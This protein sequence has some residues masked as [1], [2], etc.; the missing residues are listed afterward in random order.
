MVA[1]DQGKVVGYVLA[2]LADD[3][4]DPTPH[5]HI[6]SLAVLRSHRKLGIATKLMQAAQTEM[7][8]VYDACYVTLHVRKSNTA[9]YH[10]YSQTLGY[11]TKSLEK[12]YYA[13][14]E[15]AYEMLMKIREETAAE[16]IANKGKG[17]ASAKAPEDDKKDEKKEEKD[18]E[19]AKKGKQQQQQ[20][21]Q[22]GKQQQKAKGKK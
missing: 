7:G 20:Q 18:P 21:Q 19:A 15:D 6:T 9:A 17:G 10:L 22:K 3:D 2:K 8:S 11:T 14:G 1:L 16:K 13:D 5:G 4:E 12:E